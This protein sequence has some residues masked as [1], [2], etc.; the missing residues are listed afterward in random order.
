ME[1]YC[2]NLEKRDGCRDG[3]S[4]AQHPLTMENLTCHHSLLALRVLLASC[5]A[6][7]ECVNKKLAENH[8]SADFTSQIAVWSNNRSILGILRQD[9]GARTLCTP[10]RFLQPRKLAN[11]TAKVF[12]QIPSSEP[13]PEVLLALPGSSDIQEDAQALRVADHLR[14]VLRVFD[15]SAALA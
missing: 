7:H 5:E 1:L 10:Q 8:S 12:P 6:P 11:T 14:Q 13:N 15:K 3:R 2:H 9:G 4:F